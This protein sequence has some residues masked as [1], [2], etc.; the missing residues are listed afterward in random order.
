MVATTP[1]DGDPRLLSFYLRARADAGESAWVEETLDEW[2][3]DPAKALL[4]FDT[5]TRAV[6]R[7]I[8][9]VDSGAL[10]AAMLRWLVFG[11]W[12]ADLSDSDL[13]RILDHLKQVR[14]PVI[15]DAGI[16][17]IE[18]WTGA[19]NKQF[20]LA[21]LPLVWEFVE[22]AAE[23][24]GAALTF[25][26]WSEV[27]NLLVDVDARRTMRAVLH[28]VSGESMLPDQRIDVMRCALMRDRDSWLDLA[29][30][31]LDDERASHRLRWWVEDAGLLDS[32][33]ADYLLVWA[34]HDPERLLSTAQLIRPKLP[35][36]PL[37]RGLLAEVPAEGPVAATL[38]M[39]LRAR[40]IS[41]SPTANIQREIAS[42]EGAVVDAVPFIRAW[43]LHIITPQRDMLEQY[44]LWESEGFAEG[45]SALAA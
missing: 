13:A 4:A 6:N 5:T 38:A 16:Q 31:L 28:S 21:A 20:P 12:A 42:L 36:N 39:N 19:H 10:P 44:R 35:L 23:Q 22:R 14:D 9:Q 25:Y 3:Q 30:A 41:G 11:A 33:D 26:T 17:I 37:V 24:R 27:A 1:A 18:Q 45:A 29:A 8:G 2:A 43:L 7:L 32:V 40:E 15:T 34:N